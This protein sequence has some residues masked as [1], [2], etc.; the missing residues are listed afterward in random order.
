MLATDATYAYRREIAAARNQ[1]TARK[2]ATWQ[3]FGRPIPLSPECAEAIIEA[4]VECR[5]R[6][7]DADRA[8]NAARNTAR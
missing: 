6:W 3:R 5:I 4:W 2:L 8:L 1:Y 7:R